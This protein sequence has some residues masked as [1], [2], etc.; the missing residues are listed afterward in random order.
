MRFLAAMYVIGEAGVG[1]YVATMITRH[2]AVP[3]LEAGVNHTY[4]LVCRSVMKLDPFLVRTK[5][6][7]PTDPMHCPFQDAF[8][9]E[10]LLFE[11]LPKYPEHLNNFNLFMSGQRVGRTNWLDFFPLEEQVAS[12]FKD[13]VILVDVGGGRG[14]EI[15]AIKER[16]PHLPGRFILQD[17]PDTINQALPIPGMETMSHNFFED[18]PIKGKPMIWFQTKLPC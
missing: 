11:W 2:L 9:T 16:Y 10:E 12:A 8:G 6:Q 1:S 13:G 4:D 5:Y 14:H 3:N 7:N 17:L 18:Q 15:E